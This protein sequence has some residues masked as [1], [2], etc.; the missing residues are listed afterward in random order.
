MENQGAAAG[1]AAP[2]KEAQAPA[3]TCFKWTVG[4][5][6]SLMERAKDQYRQFTEAQASEHWEC[7]KNKVSSMFAEPIFGGGA[8][9]HGSAANTTPSVESQ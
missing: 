7:I 9:D 5:G 3:S 4:E 8:K 2:E 6:A 1:A